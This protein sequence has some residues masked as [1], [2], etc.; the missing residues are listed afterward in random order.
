[1]SITANGDDTV[2]GAQ[3]LVDNFD[4]PLDSLANSKTKSLSS[5]NLCGS[6]ALIPLLKVI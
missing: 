5:T 3:A 6:D 2:V 1:M 4:D